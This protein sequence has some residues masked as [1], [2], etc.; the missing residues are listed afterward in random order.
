MISTS[1]GEIFWYSKIPS[2]TL[3]LCEAAS[4]D[5]SDEVSAALE[6]ELSVEESVAAGADC[7]EGSDDAR[8]DQ[9][10]RERTPQDGCAARGA[11]DEDG[12]GR[13]G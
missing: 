13:A 8:G 11:P 1:V 6:S 10:A 3:S 2:F 4:E 9:S 5:V 7:P 12:S